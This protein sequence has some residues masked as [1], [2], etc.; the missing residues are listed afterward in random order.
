MYC[1]FIHVGDNCVLQQY[2]LPVSLAKECSGR[3][4]VN[5]HPPAFLVKERLINYDGGFWLKAGMTGYFVKYLFVLS[6]FPALDS[7]TH[8]QFFSKVN[9]S[10][11]SI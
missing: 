3:L 4:P 1:P 2:Y 9:S 7:K 5:P 10:P 6:V 11:Y 8:I